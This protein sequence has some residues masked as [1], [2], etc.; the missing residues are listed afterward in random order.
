MGLKLIQRFK[1]TVPHIKGAGNVIYQGFEIQCAFS[2]PRFLTL[3]EGVRPRFLCGALLVQRLEPFHDGVAYEE[4]DA[5]REEGDVCSRRVG[6]RAEQ[7]LS[8]GVACRHLCRVGRGAEEVHRC[9]G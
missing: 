6:G 5:Q 4:N 7:A 8:S 1:P 9:D 2:N 3:R